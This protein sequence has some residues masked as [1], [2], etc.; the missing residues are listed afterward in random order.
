ML[1]LFRPIS[2]EKA[3]VAQSCWGNLRRKTWTEKK[4]KV[5]RVFDMVGGKEKKKT[6]FEKQCSLQIRILQK[7]GVNAVAAFGG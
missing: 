3:R 6:I 2:I 5:R 1:L 4:E 7:V